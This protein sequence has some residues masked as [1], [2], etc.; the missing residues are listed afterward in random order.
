MDHDKIKYEKLISESVL[1]SL[2]REEQSSLYK[3]EFYKMI[4]HLYSYLMSVNQEAY[5]PYACEIMEVATRCINN[6]ECSKG[7]FLHY[8]NS[9]WK[10]EFSH[11]TGDRLIE[12][13]FRG[14][15]ITEEDKRNIRNYIRFSERKDPNCSKQELYCCI[16]DAMGLPAEK[17]RLIAELNSLSIIGDIISDGDGEE[18]NIWALIPDGRSVYNE[19]ENM[20]SVESILLKIDEVYDNLQERQKSVV[21]DMITA[22]VWTSLS[23]KQIESYRFISEEILD[24][25]FNTGK[26]PTQR[27]IANKHKRD[28]ASI[29][30]T[31]KE[32]IKKF[33]EK[34]KEV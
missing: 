31:M 23:E 24:I 11:I 8:F 3:R 26:A 22:R 16:A 29:S 7:I 27:A 6:Y 5:E 18:V 33:K 20:E 21:S 17:V 12:E 30:R 32:F 25:C 2:D 4:E 9:A 28:E 14:M 19:L 15:R 1:F 13:K 34:L 10:K